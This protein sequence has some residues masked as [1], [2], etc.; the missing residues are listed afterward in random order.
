MADPYDALV[1][2]V[3]LAFVVGPSKVA[4]NTE[5]QSVVLADDDV[6]LQIWIGT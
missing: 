3:K 4:G 5:T 2:D 6:F 1:K